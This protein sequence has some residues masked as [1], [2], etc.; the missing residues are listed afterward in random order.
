M[1]NFKNVKQRRRRQVYFLNIF[2]NPRQFNKDLLFCAGPSHFLRSLF[3]KIMFRKCAGPVQ[4]SMQ[5]LYG[6][7]MGN[8]SRITAQ[9]LCWSHAVIKYIFRYFQEFK[10]IQQRL[11][12][13]M[14]VLYSLLHKF[15][16]II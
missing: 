9:I 3:V 11:V 15:L 2:K 12:G 13:P 16:N 4:F 1:S 7:Q 10:A 6:S 14:Q 5:E 8:P